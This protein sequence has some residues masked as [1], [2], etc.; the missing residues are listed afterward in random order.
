MVILKLNIDNFIC[1]DPELLAEEGHSQ[2]DVIKEHHRHNYFP[3]ASDPQELYGICQQLPDSLSLSQNG[4]P[5]P[6]PDIKPDPDITDHVSILIG[7]LS[8]QPT[9]LCSYPFKFCEIVEQAKELV[10]CVAALNPFPS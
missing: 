7:E 5:S 2:I 3:H 10:Q 8:S 1:L 6:P 4:S 9:K